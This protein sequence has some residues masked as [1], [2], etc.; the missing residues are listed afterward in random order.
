V[1]GIDHMDEDM[2]ALLALGESIEGIDSGH[3]RVCVLCQSK[4]DQL[5][6]V[7]ATS[8]SITDEDQLLS[9]PDALWENI[10]TE[11]ESNSDSR[12]DH[13]GARGGAR[14]ARMGW[15]ALAAAVGVLVGSLGTIVISDERNPAPTV[16]QAELEPLADQDVRGVAQVRQTANGPVLLVDLPGLPDP[17]GY[18]EVWML[19]P[20]A[21]SMISVGIMGSGAVNEFP[22]PAGMDMMAFP[23]VDVSLE[24]FDGDVTHSG[25][26][27]VRGELST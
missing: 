14:G 24:E 1:S 16:A 8:R 2:I 6:A 18:Y 11:L 13:G 10:V 3:L 5:R 9:P 19:S 20:N 25:K 22:L 27:V 26:S 21:D 4:V 15:F 23:V 7:V 12:D 17:S